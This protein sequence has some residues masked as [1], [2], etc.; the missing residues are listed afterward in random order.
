MKHTEKHIE[1]SQEKNKVFRGWNRSKT[2]CSPGGWKRLRVGG[3]IWNTP[4][5]PGEACPVERTAGVVAECANPK[6][7]AYCLLCRDEGNNWKKNSD[8]GLRESIGRPWGVLEGFW[9]GKWHAESYA[10]EPNSPMQMKENVS[11]RKDDVSKD[12]DKEMHEKVY[13]YIARLISTH[14]W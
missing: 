6:S 4:E 12:R 13:D 14:F 11:C 7:W 8:S 3:G 1:M 10:L 9:L 2:S 5:V